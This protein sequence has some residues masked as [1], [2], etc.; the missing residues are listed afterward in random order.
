MKE[1]IKEKKLSLLQ[2]TIRNNKLFCG[3]ISRAIAEND[4]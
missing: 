4:T 2:M 1:E 3:K